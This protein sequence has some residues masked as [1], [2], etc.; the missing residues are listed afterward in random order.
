MS[1]FMR[2]FLFF[3]LVV[4]LSRGASAA[5]EGATGAI[6]FGHPRQSG[7]YS[8]RVRL[9]DGHKRLIKEFR[10]SVHVDVKKDGS[11][12]GKAR[13]FG[14]EFDDAF[15][16]WLA[17]LPAA[18]QERYR[19]A[20]QA[21][22]V[23]TGWMVSS[24]DTST[25]S[26]VRVYSGDDSTSQE[27][28]VRNHNENTA[29]QGPTAGNAI[30]PTASGEPVGVVFWLEGTPTAVSADPLR[31]PDV[32]YGIED[33]VFRTT[34]LPGDDREDILGR[35]AAAIRQKGYEVRFRSGPEPRIYV[36]FPRGMEF[37]GYLT[38]CLDK[39]LSIHWSMV[40][41]L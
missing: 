22:T 36:P 14:K 30:S 29:P 33:D 26:I 13:A 27:T 2:R 31:T 1:A 32:T 8:A 24:T 34:V 11:A 17:G 37:G 3:L 35:I 23:G 40:A 16:N 18:E 28:R 7:D 20:V 10:V 38:E 19:N 6:L 41:R 5:Q 9:V 21:G 12:A 25:V 39:G 15:Q 4:T